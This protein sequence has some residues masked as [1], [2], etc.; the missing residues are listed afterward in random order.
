[1]KGIGQLWSRGR[2]ISPSLPVGDDW[3]LN[4]SSQKRPPGRNLGEHRSARRSGTASTGTS[5]ILCAHAQ[6]PNSEVL[7]TFLR[8]NIGLGSSKYQTLLMEL[9]CASL[10]RH[11]H[12][13]VV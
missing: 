3:C 7:T 9:T 13:L 8:E 11:E 12:K 4:L 2:L 6:F 1:M 10:L 5:G